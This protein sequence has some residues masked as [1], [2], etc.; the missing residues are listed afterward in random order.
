MLTE[1]DDKDPHGKKLKMLK[2]QL[3]GHYPCFVVGNLPGKAMLMNSV[4]S[5]LVLVDGT[6][7]NMQKARYVWPSN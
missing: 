4:L 5:V 2:K 1:T 3:H 6:D 7:R